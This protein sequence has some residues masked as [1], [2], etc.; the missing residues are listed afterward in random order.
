[1]DLLLPF[2]IVPVDSRVPQGALGVA[3]TSERAIRY[4]LGVFSGST[5]AEILE[6]Q[7]VPVVLVP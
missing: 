2:D 6:E 1:M 5:P 4:A 7:G 3:P